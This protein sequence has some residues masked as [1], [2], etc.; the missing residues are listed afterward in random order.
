LALEVT[1]ASIVSFTGTTVLLLIY[2]L[3]DVRKRRV[4]NQVVIAGGA[5]GIAIVTLTGHLSSQVLLHLSALAFMLSVGY[6][7]F[8]MGALGGADVK[9]A[10]SLAILSPGIE[11]GSWANPIFEGIVASGLLLS[12]VLLGAYLFAKSRRREDSKIIPLLPMMLVAYLGL[13]VL[14]LI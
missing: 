3:F 7:L 4:P 11:F 5:I 10:V 6:I 13:Q 1:V 9:A 14:A 8:R 12:I 2:S